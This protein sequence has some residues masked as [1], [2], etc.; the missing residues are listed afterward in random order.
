MSPFAG[1]GGGI[2]IRINGLLFLAD[3]RGWLEGHPQQD[4]FTIADPPLDSAGIVG[5][6][7]QP[8]IFCGD[9]G[10]VVFTAPEQCSSEP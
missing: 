8:S 2:A 7:S 5:G 3:G 1:K 6:G 10:I 4:R 9:E